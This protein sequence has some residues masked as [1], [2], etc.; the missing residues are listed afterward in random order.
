MSKL[1]PQSAINLITNA[2]MSPI[3]LERPID[4][5]VRD[6][7]GVYARSLSDTASHRQQNKSQESPHFHARRL[8]WD[9]RPSTELF[10]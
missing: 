3:N 8:Q 5:H 7:C 2:R 4:L 9:F 1:A 10:L 6:A